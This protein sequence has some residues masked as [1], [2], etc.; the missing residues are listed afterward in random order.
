MKIILLQGHGEA[1]MQIPG[2]H[3]QRSVSRRKLNEEQ[4][5]VEI[6]DGASFGF[7]ESLGNSHP[8]EGFALSG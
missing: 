7:F 6:R 2:S 5:E 3:G 8:E 1:R 4:E